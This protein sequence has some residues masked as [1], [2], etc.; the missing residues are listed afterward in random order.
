[1][2]DIQLDT[3]SPPSTPS[4][5]SG[6]IFLDSTSKRPSIK[7]D[8][9]FVRSRIENFSSAQQAFV[10]TTRTYITGSGLTVPSGKMQIGSCFRWRFNLAKTGAGTASSTLDIC[11]GTAGTTADTARVSFTKP[12][13]TAVADEAWF[14]V[15][16]ICRGPL[17][18][19]GVLAGEMKM[20]HNLAATGHATIPCVCVSTISSGFDVTTAGLIVGLCLTTGA[21]DVCT[22][23]VVQAEAWNL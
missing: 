18:A 17:S 22:A 9:G 20:V 6:I 11:V 1:M 14:D 19:S 3:Q 4:S 2:A 21:S 15:M 5:G 16:A 13:G 23:E 8:A 7:D 10:A 12:A